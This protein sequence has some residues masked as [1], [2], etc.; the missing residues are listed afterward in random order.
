MTDIR[1]DY[2]PD[3]S[4]DAAL[5]Q[6][7]RDLLSTCFIGPTNEKFRRQRFNREMPPHRWLAR[8]ASGRLCGQVAIH[9]KVIGTP[10]G[11]IRMAGVAEV[12]VHPDYRGRGL[13]HRMMNQMHEWAIAAGFP[14]A[15]L[16]G[17]PRIYGGV[18]YRAVP[19]PV[20]FWEPAEN[21]W[22]TKPMEKFLARSLVKPPI[23]IPAEG[24][25]D[26]RGPRF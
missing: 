12:C 9:D 16:F 21:Q 24:L 15:T 22:L 23:V 26:L 10:I 6:E 5:D 13:A 4:V 18:G 3:A 7:L 17:D 2:T 20:R 25:I 8:D 11:D 19:N 1:I 14:L